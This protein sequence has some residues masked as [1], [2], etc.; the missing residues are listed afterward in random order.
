MKNVN[1]IND[2][3]NY[4][5]KRSSTC[6]FANSFSKEVIGLKVDVRGLCMDPNGSL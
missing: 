4:S 2:V 1:K 6:S 3:N 5:G